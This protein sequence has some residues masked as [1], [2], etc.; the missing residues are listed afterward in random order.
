M[1]KTSKEWYEKIPSKFKLKIL[2]PD[3]WDRQ[4]Y[5]YSFNGELVTYNE[6]RMRLGM[7]T[8]SCDHS[9]FRWDWELEVKLE[10]V[11]SSA[12]RFIEKHNKSENVYHN[13]NHMLYV[14]DNAMLLFSH[15]EADEKLNS[16]NKLILGLAAL[17]HDFK[18]SGG[19]LTDGENIQLSLEGMATFLGEENLSNYFDDISEIIKV[20][21]FPHKE[22]QL[23]FY[24][25]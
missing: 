1:E 20:T 23:S 16:E 12:K 4:N 2:D 10:G 21:E 19:K 6:F 7:S 5:D 17:F 11:F 13:N 24:R 14:F 25:N 22:I 8:V 3:G 15:Y 18:H 9:F